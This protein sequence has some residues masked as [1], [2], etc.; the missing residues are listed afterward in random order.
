MHLITIV[1]VSTGDM[2]LVSKGTLDVLEA[3]S[4]VIL[5]TERHPVARYLQD[6]GIRFEALD[7][8]YTEAETFDACNTA[9]AEYLLKAAEEGDVLYVVADAT[10][11]C[12]VSAL[13]KSTQDRG[14]I[15]ILPGISHANR[16]LALAQADAQDI[17]MSSAE[18]FLAGNELNPRYSLFLSEL[19][20]Q[21]CAGAC[22]IKLMELLDD[23]TEVFV[24]SGGEDGSLSVQSVPLYALDRQGHYDHLSAFLYIAKPLE[25]RKRF[26]TDDLHAVM[27]RL[28]AKNGCPWDQEQT[29]ESLLPNLLEESY[30]FIE[31]AREQDA[32]HMCEEL[33]DVLLQVMFHAVIAAQYGEFTL[34]DVTTAVTAKLIE[35]HPHVFG[36]VKADT[37][38]QVLDN[39]ENIKRTQRGIA[40]V[41]DAMDNVSKGLSAAMRASKVQHKAAKVGFDFP[42]AVSALDKVRE[43]TDEVLACIHENTETEE[44][45]GDL[46]FSVINVC[47]LSGVNP[48]IALSAAADKFIRRFRAVENR[49]KSEGKSMEALTL[50]EMDVYWTEEK[51]I[52][53]NNDG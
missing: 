40:T 28:R 21:T 37:A 6:H 24:F 23:S 11:D 20:S 3:H 35:R 49:V 38:S 1:S 7:A 43:E 27:R 41:A 8:L 5:R 33:G 46:L 44:E 15:T 26:G 10:M 19:H 30:E 29:H 12:T 39:W 45:L 36:T 50:N 52:S 16:C 51:H 14:L 42:D 47:R 18:A 4:Q 25:E 48:D 22:K 34:P 53:M 17:R 32:E 2:S 31:A 13:L 9:A